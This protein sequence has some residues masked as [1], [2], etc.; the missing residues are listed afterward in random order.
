M[1]KKF[2][3]RFMHRTRRKLAD[4]VHTG[5]YEKDEQIGYSKSV[6][7][8]EIGDKWSDEFYEYEK[9]DGYIVKKSKNSNTLQK[10]R[11]FLNTEEQ[12]KNENCTTIGYS[13]AD[14]TLI[15]KR[16]YC[17]NCLTEREHKIRVAGVFAEYE[18]YIIWTNM[19]KDGLKRIEEMEQAKKD[20]KQEFEFINDDGTIEK[21]E[22]P[23]PVDEVRAE[24]TEVLETW[25]KEI[26]ELEINIEKVYQVLKSRGVEEYV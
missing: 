23:Q 9:K 1:A 19:L 11:Q 14:K 7:E 13:K 22:L 25:Y 12:C 4:M 10:V 8:R 21:W 15:K 17:V 6:E 26:D 24:I 18:K 5:E 20:L 16:G 2:Q 3:R